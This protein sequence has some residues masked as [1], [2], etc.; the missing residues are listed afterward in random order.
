MARPARNILSTA[1]LQQGPR[2]LPGLRTLPFRPLRKK[3][4]ILTQVTGLRFILSEATVSPYKQVQG[5]SDPHAPPPPPRPQGSA[6]SPRLQL[7]QSPWPSPAVRASMTCPGSSRNFC[8]CLTCR[9]PER[10]FTDRLSRW[11]PPQTSSRP[12][13]SPT[14]RGAPQ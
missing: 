6:P 3:L 9:H 10:P 12:R 5:T 13:P 4:A 2:G 11:F 14:C 1:E 8:S 7:A